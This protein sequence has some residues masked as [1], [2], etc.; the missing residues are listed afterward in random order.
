L[1]TRNGTQ[2]SKISAWNCGDA[3]APWAFERTTVAS[4]KSPADHWPY[5]FSALTSTS[6]RAGMQPLN[7]AKVVC[8]SAEPT[9]RSQVSA[10][11]G[12]GA[13][14]GRVKPSTTAMNDASEP[15]AAT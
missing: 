6:V 5:S 14:T 15:G 12:W 4:A 10:F 7:G 2:A 3:A 9:A 13:F 1:S 11:T 8:A